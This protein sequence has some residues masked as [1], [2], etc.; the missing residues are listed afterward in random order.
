MQMF[1]DFIGRLLFPRQQD[2]AQRKNAKTLV[3][4]IGF[5]LLLGVIMAKIF[6]ILYN[7][8]R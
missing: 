1:Y 7:H 3:F 6:R 4:T 2:W 8:Q 5:T